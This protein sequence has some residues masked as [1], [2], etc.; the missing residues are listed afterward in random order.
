M[1]RKRKKRRKKVA[2]LY[3]YFPYYGEI[4]K[5]RVILQNLNNYR[6]FMQIYVSRPITVR[7][8]LVFTTFRRVI[9][10]FTRDLFQI[11]EF[12]KELS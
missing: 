6:I 10:S 1:K 2:R 12:P 9:F 4:S 7:H 11:I 5:K 3:I 8:V